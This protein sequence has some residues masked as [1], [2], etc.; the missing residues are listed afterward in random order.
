MRWTEPRG[1]GLA[2]GRQFVP[3]L[4]TGDDI[5]TSDSASLVANR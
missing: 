1:H 2:S 5:G 4:Y 3:G